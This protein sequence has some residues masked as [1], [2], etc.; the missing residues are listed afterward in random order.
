M[1]VPDPIREG[2]ARGW[3]AIDAAT[4]AADRELECDV[5][6]IGS[7]AGGGVTAEILANAGF[8][9]VILE[10]GP[11][12][13]SSEFR[14]RE[15]EAY[16][17]LYQE[18]AGRQ[19][20]DKGITILQG[21]C[22]GGGTTINWTSSFRTPPRTLAHWNKA[23]GL[24]ALTETA[25]A[26]WFARMEERLSIAPWS[27]PPNENNDILRRGTTKLGISHGAIRRNVKGCGN[28]GYCGMGCPLN[29]KQSMLVTTIPAALDRGATLVHR[30]RVT[31]L[32]AEGDRLVSCE[33]YGVERNGAAQSSRRVRVRARHFVVAAGAINTPAILISSDI[34]DPN[35]LLGK[36]TFLHPTVVSGSVFPQ[37]VEGYYGAP[38]TIYSDHFL[39]GSALDG[40]I[41]FK[42]EAPPVHPILGGIT[43]PGFGREHARW[44]TRFPNLQVLIALM[45]D[46]FHADSPGGQVVIRSGW[47]VL[48]YP[49]NDY[50]WNG[51]RRAY[52]AMAEIQFAA[53]AQT[54][55]PLHEGAQPVSSWREAKAVIEGLALR[56]LH[57]RVV[58]AH[59]MGGCPM[60]SDP[61][62]SVVNDAGRH[63]QVQNLS[64]HDASTFPTSVGANP[65]LT[66]YALAARHATALAASLKA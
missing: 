47:P 27:V 12:V 7:G 65:Q 11:L 44:M 52:L 1:S 61:R 51:V 8:S 18:S 41:G 22:V 66:I 59:V 13:G 9:V 15:R 54:V 17:R 64:V 28:L 55:M 56:P 57:A 35:N 36:R 62:T 49:L 34:P 50:V 63:H 37:K 58:S 26:P 42:L 2:L 45:R 6:V 23:H 31:R 14:M 20:L 21:R 25:L 29:A 46:G 39:D 19:T 3:K 5:A 38:Q 32:V 48:D 10:E 40:P 16:P 43:L 24:E 53:G 30:A 4:L 33:A 60:G